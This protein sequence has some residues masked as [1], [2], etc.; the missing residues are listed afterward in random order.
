M[1]Q[2]QQAPAPVVNPNAPPAA[3]TG[4]SR[5]TATKAFNRRELAPRPPAHAAEK[6]TGVPP[7]LKAVEADDP[8]YDI[9][10]TDTSSFVPS[11]DAMFV[12]IDEMDEQM[13]QTRRFYET[14][15]TWHPL[16]TQ[17]YIGILWIMAT[18]R[19]QIENGQADTY[20]VQFYT[21]FSTTFPLS[22]LTI[23]G[24]LVP[25]FQALTIATAPFES[26]GNV[27]VRLPR[28]C[29]ATEA[30]CFFTQ[31]HYR[32]LPPIPYIMEQMQ[33]LYATVH[34]VGAP[35]V[36]LTAITAAA[37]NFHDCSNIIAVP[38]AGAPLAA[39][40]PFQVAVANANVW[41]KVAYAA[42]GNASNV[43]INPAVTMN[44]FNNGVILMNQLPARLTVAAPPAVAANMLWG[45]YCR[46]TTWNAAPESQWFKTIS[47]T[48]A[49]YSQFFRASTTFDK[50]STRGLGVVLFKEVLSVNNHVTQFAHVTVEVP[51]AAGPPPVAARRAFLHYSGS[52]STSLLA[53]AETSDPTMPSLP[54]Q[55]ALISQINPDYAVVAALPGQPVGYPAAALT[56]FG[57]FWNVAS[58]QRSIE[59]DPSAGVGPNIQKYYHVDT[60]ITE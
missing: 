55:Y 22:S 43:G 2:Q 21:W 26:Y 14:Q 58:E 54:A 24:P 50:I 4:T 31:Q 34:P 29:N 60:R 52:A 33:A 5:A 45:D 16:V 46:F 11:A 48:M 28:N 15:M 20:L 38:A 35:A 47:T 44:F 19:V 7:L 9:Q 56:R 40:G 8:L 1:E 36:P 49:R 39:P 12:V 41:L 57:P 27:G 25:F 10:H 59:R 3:P 32:H 53:I 51:A 6:D 42:P 37:W 13:A 30:T 18:I 23:P 17:L